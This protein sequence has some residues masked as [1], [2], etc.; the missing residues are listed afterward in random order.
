MTTREEAKA[1]NNP[2]PLKLTF[3]SHAQN[4]R[5]LPKAQPFSV[6]GGLPIFE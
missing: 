2:E 5:D 4:T 6:W 3:G 1:R